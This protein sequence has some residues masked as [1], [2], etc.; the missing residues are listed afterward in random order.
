MAR[1]PCL[2]VAFAATIMFLGM[3]ATAQAQPAAAGYPNKPIRWVVPYTPGGATDTVARVFGQ[4]LQEAWKQPVV[5]ENRPGAASNIGSDIVAKAAPDGYTLLLV[6]PTLS[7]NA[8]LFPGTLTY[9]PARAFAPVSQIIGIPNAVLVPANS[10][11]QRIED[12]IAHAKANPGKL[13]YASAGIGSL[14]HLG[15]ELFKAVVGVDVAHVAYK[16]SAPV[17]QDLIAGNVPMASDNLPT[18]LPQVKAGKERALVVLGPRRVPAL[19]EVRTMPEIGFVGFDGSGWAGV[20]VPAATPRAIVD[21]LSREIARIAQLPDVRKRFEDV[22]FIM[23]ASTPD[24]FGAFI[25][26]E[27]VKWEKLIRDNAIKVE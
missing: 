20:A 6:T 22:G 16:G 4:K 14:T 3:T 2:H 1:N 11:F 23:I 18:H 25:K 21:M 24:E 26:T 15:F 7:T 5:V 12:L 19:P 9:D 10:P 17:I 13:T 8:A 27:T